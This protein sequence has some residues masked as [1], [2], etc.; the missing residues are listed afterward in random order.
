MSMSIENKSDGYQVYLLRLWRAPCKGRWECR[1]SIESPG[2]GE[3]QSFAN[4][5]QLSIHL[6]EQFERQA[7]D[8]TTLPAP[9]TGGA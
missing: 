9:D 1:A 5:E 3:R 7:P 4:L 8:P 2:S 6:R